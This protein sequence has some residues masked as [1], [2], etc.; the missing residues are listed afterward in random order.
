MRRAGLEP[1]VAITEMQI[2]TNRP[3]LPNNKS[4]AEALW[5]ASLLHTAIR[6]DG[7]IELITHSALLNHGGGLGKNRSVVYAEPVWWATPL[8]SAQPGTVPVRVRLDSPTFSTSGK[9]ITRREG[10]PYV[11]AAALLDP[12]GKTVVTFLVNRHPSEAFTVSL[13]TLGG[14]VQHRAGRSLLTAGTLLDRNAW[15]SP[16]GVRPVDSEVSISEVALPPLSLTRV[17]LRVR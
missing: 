1:K 12:A 6:S 13:S 5:L 9:Y 2:F 3:G 10:V 7:V 15:D 14:D 8:Y 11:D 16:N 4:I 17:S